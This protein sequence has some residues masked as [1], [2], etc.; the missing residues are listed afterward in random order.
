MPAPNLG[1]LSQPLPAQ[2]P[3]AAAPSPATPQAPAEGR[4]AI[5]RANVMKAIQSISGEL[6]NF[7]V[8]S[9]E[10]TALLD[11]IK[12]LG[13]FFSGWSAPQTPQPAQQSA[14]QIQGSA[15]PLPQ[16]DSSTEP[17]QEAA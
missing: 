10:H 15:V 13:K 9:E 14:Q 6:A 11:S 7:P 1:V 4:S 12:K 2:T 8:G 16:P 3:A 17:S 5:A